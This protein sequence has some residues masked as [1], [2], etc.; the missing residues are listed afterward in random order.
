MTQQ[1][2]F[3]KS[4]LCPTKSDENSLQA[5]DSFV[6]LQPT[7]SYSC[8][9]ELVASEYSKRAEGSCEISEY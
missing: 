6:Q 3:C 5:D 1:N 8:T 4:A 7:I 9:T 2:A